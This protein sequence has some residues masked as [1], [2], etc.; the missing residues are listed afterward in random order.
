[1]YKINGVN[2]VDL[3]D[4][5][6]VALCKDHDNEAITVLYTRFKGL[7]YTITFDISR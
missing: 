5:D 4:E 1:M 6:L 7:I 3:S 2:L